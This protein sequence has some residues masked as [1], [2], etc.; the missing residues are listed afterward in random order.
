MPYPEGMSGE[1]QDS[2]VLAPF[3][4][5]G[6]EFGRAFFSANLKTYLLTACYLGF[7]F[8]FGLSF[9]VQLPVVASVWLAAT[10]VFLVAL[11]T[12]II[13]RF[14]RFG[15]QGF[16]DLRTVTV[17]PTGIRVDIDPWIESW[18]A[19]SNILKVTEFEDLVIFHHK[20]RVTSIYARS[21]WTP[22]A[23]DILRANVKDVKLK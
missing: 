8:A 5:S 19:W 1:G 11:R 9:S 22:E 4:L 3:R 10:L 21:V 2:I 23:I 17:S 12:G 14:R 18:V 16:D 6:S 7:V 15:P 13:L 20:F